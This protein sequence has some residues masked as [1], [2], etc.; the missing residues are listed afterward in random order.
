MTFEVD[1]P[2]HPHFV[3]PTHVAAADGTVSSTYTSSANDPPG[4]YLIKAVGSRGTR[5]QASLVVLGANP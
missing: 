4:T 5:A 1:I 2:H 3:G